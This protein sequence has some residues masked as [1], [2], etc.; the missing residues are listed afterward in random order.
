MQAKFGA[1]VISGS[2]KIGGQAFSRTGGRAKLSAIVPGQRKTFN[3]SFRQRN[4]ITVLSQAWRG[5]S[6]VNRQSWLQNAIDERSAF[7][8]YVQRNSNAMRTMQALYT[9]FVINVG[10]FR[11]LTLTAGADASAGSITFAST[12]TVT[13]TARTNIFLSRQQ[14]P[15]TSRNKCGYFCIDY[16]Q[17]FNNFSRSFTTAYTNR[18]GALITGKRIFYKLTAINAQSGATIFEREGSFLVSP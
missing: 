17:E 11:L 1:I 13:G 15:G 7:N 10:N 9:A 16:A 8:L 18:Y 14:S 12:Q 3:N 2:G 6:L 5:L 4:V